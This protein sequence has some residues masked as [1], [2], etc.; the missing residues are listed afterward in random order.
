MTD[1]NGY[2]IY[3]RKP[4]TLYVSGTIIAPGSAPPT[5]S[6]IAGWNLVGYKPQPDV[7]TKTVHDYLSS[8]D[9]KYDESNVWVY[10]NVDGTWSRGV[11]TTLHPG[12]AMWIYMNSA[13]TLNP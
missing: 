7:T 12:D 1:G 13:A 9:T 2:W 10:N 11:L 5:Y 4:D 3:M 8:I 6:L